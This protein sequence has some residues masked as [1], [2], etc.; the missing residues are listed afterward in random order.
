MVTHL[1][2][3]SAGGLSIHQN[4]LYAISESNDGT[5]RLDNAPDEIVAISLAGALN[6]HSFVPYQFDTDDFENFYVLSA[7]TLSGDIRHGSTFNRVRVQKY[8]KSTDTWSTI[9][10]PDDGEPQLAHPVDLIEEIGEFADSRKNDLQVVRHNNETLIFYRRVEASAAGIAYKNETDDTLTNIYS[11]TFGSNDGL[12]YSMDF[13]L[14]ERSD[15]I[16][17]YTFVVKYTLSGSTFTSATLKVYR[18][19]VEPSGAQTEIFSETFTGTSGTDEYPISVSSIILADDRSKFYFTLDYFSES[20]TEA[21][22]AELCEIAKDGTGSRTVLKTYDNSLVGPRSPVE[23]GGDYYYLEG[24]WVRRV[25]DDDDVPDKFYYPNEGGRLIEIESNGDITDHGVIWRSATKSDSPDIGADRYNG[26]GLHN[27]VVSNMIVYDNSLRVVAGYGNP[28][29]IANNLPTVSTENQALDFANF[30]QIERGRALAG[31]IASF[32]V[33]GQR[34]LALIQALA[35]LGFANV[36]V[37]PT[38]ITD[39]RLAGETVSAW[40]RYASIY[41][42]SRNDAQVSLRTAVGSGAVSQLD[43]D[44]VGLPDTGEVLFGTEIFAYTSTVDAGGV[45][46]RIT[47]A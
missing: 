41:Y 3:G 8:V 4:R 38:A 15:G 40:Q 2:T 42:R 44:A 30:V 11:E 39:A 21:G 46:S 20:A 28:F 19:R 18:E 24:G 36:G 5:P 27:A 10:D 7:N 16:Y 12:P 37:P 6:Y 25:S 13:V 43:V 32:P 23:N 14:D 34:G 29:R 45:I 22:K 33:S 31:K 47:K 26:Y 1:E 9:L 17:V 35:S